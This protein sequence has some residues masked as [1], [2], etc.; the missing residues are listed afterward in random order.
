[1]YYTIYQTT[2]AV[3]GK[4]YIGKHQT[5]SLDDDYFG[6]GIGIKRAISYHG[7]DNFSKEILHIFETEDEM[8]AKE[9]ELITEEFVARRD[10][11]N[12]GVGGEG[13]AHFKGRKHTAETKRILSEKAKARKH[14]VEARAKISEANRR[15]TISEETRKKLSEK[16]KGRKHSEETKR[17]LSEKVKGRKHSEETKR[18]MSEKARQRHRS[19]ATNL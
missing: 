10:T 11:Y 6:S 16:A 19:S 8:N 12:I 14:T 5:K 4:I 15:R 7:K 18:K 1:M 9:R 2:N 17:K 3:N 13:G